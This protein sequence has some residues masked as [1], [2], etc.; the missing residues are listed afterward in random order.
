MRYAV[1]SMTQFE[2]DAAA[3]LPL[4]LLP[5]V[6]TP[7]NGRAIADHSA[8]AGAGQVHLDVRRVPGGEPAMLVEDLANT[9]AGLP[10]DFVA[11]LLVESTAHSLTPVAVRHADHARA[12]LLFQRIC[13]WSRSWHL[14]D[15]SART[16]GSAVVDLRSGPGLPLDRAALPEPIRAVLDEEDA[17]D[18]VIVPLDG[19]VSPQGIA[20][21]ARRET[22]F[23]DADRHVAVRAAGRC[24]RGLELARLVSAA[25]SQA[26][27]LDMLDDA[28]VT[29]DR[30]QA[31]TGWNTAAERMYGLSA[32]ESLGRRAT[33]LVR[34]VVPGAEEVDVRA[35][36]ESGGTW[37][38]RARQ[39]SRSGVTVET[40]VR[41]SALMD[42][43]GRPR[44]L[45]SV[46]RDVTDLVAAQ[47]D[48]ALQGRLAQELMDALG[49]R[50]A[51]LDAQGR[52]IAA[53]ARWGLGLSDRARCVCGPVPEGA[54]WLFAL[55]RSSAME[56]RNLGADVA[57][58]LR[59]ETRTV[60]VECRCDSAGP[61][62]ATAVEV[63]RVDA[64][65]F[66][67]V[68]MLANAS[69]RRRLQE[70]LRF[71]ATHDELTGLP[72]RSA[73]MEGLSDSLRRLDGTRKL[74]VLFCDLDGFKDI[75][76]GL[77]HAVGDQVLVAVARRLRQRCR[78]ADVVAR[79][80][81]DEFVVVLS[82]GDVGQA[83]AMADRIVEVLAEPIVVGD[84]EVAPGVSVGITVVDVAP[85]DEDPV[86][87]L[88]RD[89]DTAMYHAKDK[90]RGRYEFFDSRLRENISQR[91]ELAA[92]LH[93]A[94]RDDELE[95]VYQTRRTCGDRRVAGVEALLQWRH[96]TQGLVKPEVFIPIAERTG[97]IIDV[98]AWVLQRALADFAALPAAVGRPTLAVNVSPRQLGPRLPRTVADALAEARIEPNRLVLEI[99]ES[100]LMDDPHTTR[101]VLSDLRELGVSIALDDF[102]TGRSSLSFLRTVPV[103]IL[104]ID[105][106]FVSE[107]AGADPDAIAVVL[108]VLNLG[109]GMGL[110]V[111]AEGVEHEDDLAVLR[112]MG[113][114]EYQG[115]IDGRPGP[116]SDVL[117]HLGTAAA[118]SA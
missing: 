53:N 20:V 41:I 5:S 86:G 19:R 33:D 82:I 115:F 24:G 95:I 85:D 55:Q 36:L 18:V 59:G 54:N 27:L 117:S 68:V 60:Q 44:G 21:L 8:G 56:A 92:A 26:T 25:H 66:G 106:S 107:L 31:V 100:A 101:T 118:R 34:T 103:D 4:P 47:A 89:A 51:V 42:P 62:G 1:S 49:S 88:L 61:E 102:G 69:Q 2:L 67:A 77:G 64:G 72:N 109:H 76:D 110:V 16:W 29:L 46:A 80:G 65:Q 108:A 78:S 10:A 11:V 22:A 30:D 50:A 7:G 104:K 96:P 3:G 39:T 113:C 91:L 6:P 105:R 73:L 58:L 17:L 28:V 15:R 14:D 97:R 23:R 71:R 74:A 70:E 13:G 87:T 63:V 84:A 98:G 12:E 81:G 9:L 45:M 79:F 37:R 114:D 111:V 57:G 90:G 83:V 112:D 93:R 35:L 94:V 40:D 116:L 52:V 32:A 38:G 43:D 99:T 48:A 75:N